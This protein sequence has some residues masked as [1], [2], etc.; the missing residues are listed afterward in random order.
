MRLNQTGPDMFSPRFSPDGLWVAG[1]GR[2]GRGLYLAEASGK[3]PVAAVS[4]THLGPWVWT[5]GP[6][7]LRFAED[8]GPAKAFDP[9]RRMVAER[10]EE[11]PWVRP[12]DDE[13]GELLQDGQRG[14]W[15]HHPW[16]G[17]VTHTPIGK[18]ARLVAAEDAWGAA[19]SP[20]GR[21]LAFSRGLLSDSRF[22]VHD[23][24]K[25]VTRELGP[26][27]H[28]AWMPELGIVIYAVPSGVERVGGMA[29]VTGSELW[30]YDFQSGRHLALTATLDMAEMEPA[31][32]P[33]GDALVFSDWRGGGIWRA[34]LVQG[35]AP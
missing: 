34:S 9:V 22:F 28:P 35:G 21:Y 2:G 25:G 5:A 17:T 24:E 12:M 11:R 6:V 8:F 13:L 3:V 27:V 29:N 4:A 31:L 32:A 18:R 30:L 33:R 20:D 10:G 19:V 15:H 14:R 23:S 1:A 7:E 16:R 26:G